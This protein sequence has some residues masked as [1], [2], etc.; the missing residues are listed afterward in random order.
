MSRYA[1]QTLLAAAAA[2]DDDDDDS[3]CSTLALF[4]V[5]VFH[6]SYKRSTEAGKGG[7]KA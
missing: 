5:D 7:G 6:R 3:V 1:L 2:D 4:F